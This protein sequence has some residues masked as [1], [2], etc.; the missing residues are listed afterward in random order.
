MPARKTEAP[1]V[2]D[3][4]RRRGT[5]GASDGA[6]DAL[7]A[8]PIP[9]QVTVHP[10][11]GI[12]RNVNV[13]ELREDDTAATLIEVVDVRTILP[14]KSLHEDAHVKEAVPVRSDIRRLSDADLMD[15]LIEERHARLIEG[16]P[17]I[18]DEEMYRFGDDAIET[19]LLG[20]DRDLSNQRRREV[21]RRIHLLAPKVSMGEPGLIAFRNGVVDMETG[22]MSPNG[23]ELNIPNVIPHDFRP[24]AEPTM[25]D[26]CLD[27]WACGRGDVR[28]VLEEV[29][30]LCMYRGRDFGVCPILIGKGANG[31]STY[32]NLLR[33]LLGEGNTS[34]QDMATIGERF[35][36]I[37]L[38]G[39]LANIGDDI[40]TGRIGA[41]ALSI[42]KRAIT[43]DTLPAEYK[44][45]ESF[46]FRPYCTLVFSCNAMPGLDDR[47]EGMYRRLHPVPFKAT[48]SR[49][50][51]S[52]D[53]AK[54][55]ELWSEASIERL[56]HL[57]IEGLLRCREQGGLTQT[58]DR[59]ELMRDIRM[60]NS[61]VY[62]Y[63]AV[64][65]GLDVERVRGKTTKDL[66]DDYREF[67]E[68]EGLRPIAK[69]SFSKELK[70]HFDV[71]HGYVVD[72]E[73]NKARGFV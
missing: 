61:N 48:F 24:D 59:T 9:S 14:P 43:G 12:D 30:G 37:P 25:V 54:L 38:M 26:E 3:S 51:G 21:I 22:E 40:P 44:G 55:R 11:D 67:C 18:W 49:E 35:Q 34:A 39:V 1:T 68:D 7:A 63:A 70:E 19:A 47:T 6:M 23:P 16:A 60:Q 5:E 2:P 27:E 53:P 41:K 57:G 69:N 72:S 52:A 32:L 42:V 62:H 29:V 15:L 20:I 4:C 66:Y 50:D 71:E 58:E 8:N 33:H 13:V 45:R 31:K 64:R 73:G 36:S 28:A 10:L 65:L 46:S 17:A 56:I